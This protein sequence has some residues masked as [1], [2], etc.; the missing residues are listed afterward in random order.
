MRACEHN[1]VRVPE[2]KQ[3]KYESDTEDIATLQVMLL[4]RLKEKF[5]GCVPARH[6]KEALLCLS[7]LCAAEVDHDKGFWHQLRVLVAA[8][9]ANRV[10]VVNCSAAG[11]APVANCA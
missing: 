6:S 11:H 10:A 2:E 5:R 8:N 4:A 9:S 1:I 7:Y 3:R